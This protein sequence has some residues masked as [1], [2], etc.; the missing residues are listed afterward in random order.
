MRAVGWF[1]SDWRVRTRPLG[2]QVGMGWF[3]KILGPLL[4]FFLCLVIGGTSDL[5][6]LAI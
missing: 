4:L 2:C 3:C 6:A 5:M 1:G